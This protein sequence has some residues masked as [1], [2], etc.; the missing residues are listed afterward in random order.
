MSIFSSYFWLWSIV[1]LLGLVFLY[2][3]GAVMNLGGF[4]SPLGRAGRWIDHSPLAVKFL[5][6]VGLLGLLAY[7]SII[8]K[9]WADAT[10]QEVRRAFDTLPTPPTT[11]LAPTTEQFSG[12]YDPT[13]TDGTYIIGWFGTSAPFTE[14][15]SFYEKGLGEKGWV[16]QENTAPPRS[17]EATSP[18]RMEF[19]DRADAR[20]A[21]YELLLTPISSS[22]LEIPAQLRSEPTVYAIRLGVVDPRVTTQVAWFIDCLVRRAPTFPT[23]EAAG[24]N[25]LEE[26]SAPG[27]RSPGG[28]GRGR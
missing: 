13:G 22:S 10:A 25:P 3:L 28:S 1:G 23:C 8:H 9:L 17:R 11:R 14:V 24:W 4:I 21:H 12:L 2:T 19:R 20:Q 6:A 7:P 16:L 18:D 27:L 26:A 15:R 5:I